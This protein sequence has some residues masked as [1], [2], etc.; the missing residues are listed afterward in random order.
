MTK[1]EEDAKVQAAKNS[2]NSS[3]QAS[4]RGEIN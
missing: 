1:A 3:S 2:E 4:G